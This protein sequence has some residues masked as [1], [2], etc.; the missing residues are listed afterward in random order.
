MRLSSTSSSFFV[1]F[2]NGKVSSVIEMSS[3]KVLMISFYVAMHNLLS[4]VCV[5]GAQNVAN[6]RV[7][8]FGNLL[9]MYEK[10]TQYFVKLIPQLFT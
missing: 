1:F 6:D 8:F 3:V 2:V 5:N 7:G 4:K 10:C 9:I